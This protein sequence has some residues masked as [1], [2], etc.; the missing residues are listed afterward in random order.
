MWGQDIGGH[1]VSKNLRIIPTR[2]GTRILPLVYDDSLRDHPHACGDK[3]LPPVWIFGFQGSSPRV[4]GQVPAVCA[5]RLFFGIIPTRVGTSFFLLC[6]FL[7]FKDHPHACGDK[8]MDED[9]VFGDTGSSPRVW[10]Q[11]LPTYQPLLQAGIIPTR[12]GT[13]FRTYHTVL[14]NAGSSPRV[15][16][17]GTKQK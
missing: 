12:V 14:Q 4:W 3:F 6:G 9:D 8:W 15:W 16:G 17:Q 2:V 7:V 5:S 1:T 13:S 11:V 10:G